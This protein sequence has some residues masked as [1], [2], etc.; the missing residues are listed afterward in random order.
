MLEYGARGPNEWDPYSEVWETRPELVL[1]LVDRMRVTGEDQS[2]VARNEAVAADRDAATEEVLASLGDDEE[3]KGLVLAAQG[4]AQR[5][6]AWR[7]RTK[8][9][10]V[11]AIHEQRM[12]MRELGRRGVERGR[13]GRPAAGVHAARRGA[14][15][16]HRRPLRPSRSGWASDG[17]RGRSCG[18]SNRRISSRATKASRRCRAWPAR[19]PPRSRWRCRVTC[20]RAHRAVPVWPGARRGSCST[21]AIRWRSSP[22]TSWSRRTRIRPGRRC[23][24]PPPGVI[25]DVGAMNSHAVIVS[26]ELG[27]PCAV[28]VVDATKRIPDGSLV[29]VDGGT[30]TVT[31]L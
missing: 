18:R 30:G 17:R 19:G 4:S 26:R 16:L 12:A 13:V 9:N 27:I 10:C 5:F 29:E 25:V 21:P 3:T 20:W 24:S 28:S 22:A 2:P 15:R 31:M 14:G 6:L 11:K 7:E 1:A 23:S 8:T